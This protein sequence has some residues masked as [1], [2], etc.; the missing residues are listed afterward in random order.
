MVNRLKL[1]IVLSLVM[2]LAS[3]A[4]AQTTADSAMNAGAVPVQVP[5]EEADTDF[6]WGLLGLLGL[7]GL[8]GRKREDKTVYVD[9]ATTTR[10]RTP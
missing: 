5:V 7:A 4:G 6:P 3:T 2:S 1:A 10:P 8:M 9:P